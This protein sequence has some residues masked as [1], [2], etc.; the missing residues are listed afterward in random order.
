MVLR[1]RNTVRAHHSICVH[2]IL[3]FKSNW[4]CLMLTFFSGVFCKLFFQTFIGGIQV[5]NPVSL[6]PKCFYICMS[7]Y[8]VRQSFLIFHC[9]SQF[10][11]VLFFL[12]EGVG[13]SIFR[14]RGK[15]Q[16]IMNFT[17]GKI[18]GPT[19][20]NAS[21]RNLLGMVSNWKVGQLSLTW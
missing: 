10:H 20:W 3:H 18:S 8:L 4:I 2:S 16:K 6:P 14:F 5:I 13:Y 7:Q 21:Y 11:F 1:P 19:V 17:K 15:R 9:R 12:E